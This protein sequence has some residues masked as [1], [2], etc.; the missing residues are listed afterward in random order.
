LFDAGAAFHGPF[1]EFL[2]LLS[3]TKPT[4]CEEKLIAAFTAG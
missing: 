2:L 4:Q 1:K 3:A